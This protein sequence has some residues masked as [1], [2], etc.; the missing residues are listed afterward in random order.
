[1]H[2]QHKSKVNISRNTYEQIVDEIEHDPLIRRT[3]IYATTL[4]AAICVL[5]GLLLWYVLLH[6][7]KLIRTTGTV[8]SINS[9]RTDNIGTVTTFITFDFKTSDGQA[10]SVKAP[11]TNG[12]TYT[13]G[14]PLSVGYSPLNPNYARNLS[15]IKPPRISVVLW[16]IPFLLLIWFGFVALFRHH[17]RQVEIWDAAEAAKIAAEA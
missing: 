4:T 10:K 15:H 8:S 14:D 5:T 1:M 9:G 17:A 12:H 11:V 6:P 7:A 13:A 2:I 3:T 16:T